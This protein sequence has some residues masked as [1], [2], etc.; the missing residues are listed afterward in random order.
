MTAPLSLIAGQWALIERPHSGVP[1]NFFTFHA[2]TY[3]TW[4]YAHPML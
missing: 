2:T 1:G 4:Q 3:S